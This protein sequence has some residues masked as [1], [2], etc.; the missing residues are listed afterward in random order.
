MTVTNANLCSHR[1][2]R[3]F[4]RNPIG[5][6]RCELAAQQF[7]LLAYFNQIPQ[8]L[9]ESARIDGA[10][11]GRYFRSVILPPSGPMLAA[12]FVLDFVSTWNEFPIALTLLQTYDWWT[13]PLGLLSFLGPFT[14]DYQL[15]SSAIV[16]AAIPVLVVYFAMQRFFV[17]GLTAGRPGN[18]QPCGRAAFHHCRSMSSS[19]GDSIT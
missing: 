11:A 14:N 19:S 5:A 7:F 18:N 10:G 16:I 15:L 17:S 3:S 9:E 8:E 12:L 4:D 2:R 1:L 6:R 13:V